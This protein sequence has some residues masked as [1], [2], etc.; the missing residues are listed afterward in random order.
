MAYCERAKIDVTF[1]A[2]ETIARASRYTPRRAIK[3][4]ACRDYAFE[5]TGDLHAKLDAETVMQGLE[6]AEVDVYGLDS[7]DRRTADIG[8]RVYDGPVG[9]APLAASLGMDPTEL[10]KD[11]EPYLLMAGL[12]NQLLRRMVESS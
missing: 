2:A 8:H 10:T 4:V 7:R 9:L 3:L 12:L 11:V 6:Y 5:V 1:E